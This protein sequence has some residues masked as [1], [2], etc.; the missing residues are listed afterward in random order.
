M[1]VIAIGV[2]GKESF[3]D[4][5]ESWVVPVRGD[6]I[7]LGEVEVV[8]FLQRP[9]PRWSS[10][11]RRGCGRRRGCSSRRGCGRRRGCSSR[12]GCSLVGTASCEY[13]SSSSNTD[14][15]A[16]SHLH[17]VPARDLTAAILLNQLVKLAVLSRIAHLSR[18]PLCTY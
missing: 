11:R 8:A 7:M 5:K 16:S 14:A 1:V 12:R 3:V 4:G 18:T 17:E 9:A 6:R 2:I 13:R 15:E 10:S